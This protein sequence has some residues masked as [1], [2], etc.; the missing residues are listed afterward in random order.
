MKKRLGRLATTAASL[1][2]M[3]FLGTT[4]A[5]ALNLVENGGFESGDFSGWLRNGAFMY[6]TGNHPLSGAFA[7]DL[8]TAGTL[9][10]LS[11]T[12]MTM[13]GYEYELRFDLANS[14]GLTNEF[15]ALVNGTTLFSLVNGGNTPYATVSGVFT[16][17]ATP[18]EITFLERNDVGAFSM[19]NV[20]VDLAPVPEPS[21][22]LLLGIGLLGAGFLRK[23][24]QRREQAA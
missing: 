18:T 11:Q 17:G 4:S 3:L 6:V 1:A 10:S 7:A 15:Y 5:S 12:V 19:D 22:L 23:R 9:G 2:L 20:S 13:P 24:M 16:A 8:G 21:T 14:G